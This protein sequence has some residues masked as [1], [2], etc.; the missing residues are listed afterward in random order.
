MLLTLGFSGHLKLLNLPLFLFF[1]LQVLV[2]FKVIVFL[3]ALVFIKL[4]AFPLF[5]PS[6]HTATHPLPLPK[7]NITL[8]FSISCCVNSLRPETST[9]SHPRLL[10]D[11]LSV[12]S[13]H[14]F[15]LGK[16]KIHFLLENLK[17]CS[18][19]DHNGNEGHSIANNLARNHDIALQVK[20]N[21][22]EFEM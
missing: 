18:I 11:L 13:I 21:H 1:C 15:C 20:I 5:S 9:V 19:V 17:K 16:H 12:S 8:V 6:P 7:F 22:L 10:P 2:F 4:Q 14:C 3:T